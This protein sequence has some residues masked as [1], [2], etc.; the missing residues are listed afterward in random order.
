MISRNVAG[1]TNVSKDYI[2]SIFKVGAK[3]LKMEVECSSQMLVP[4]YQTT[5]CHNPED[6]NVKFQC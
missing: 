1:D 2:A 5:W 3:Y 6:H 4:T